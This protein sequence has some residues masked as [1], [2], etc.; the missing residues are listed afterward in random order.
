MDFGLKDIVRKVIVI[1]DNPDIFQT[2]CDILISEKDSREVDKMEAELFGH[3]QHAAGSTSMYKCE[4][5]YAPQGKDGVTIIK[6]ASEE[7][8]PFSLAFVDMRMPPGWNGLETIKHIWEIDPDIQAVICTAYS[9]YSW[10]ELVGHLGLTDNLLI[11]KKPFD[12]AEVSQ[13]TSA[14]TSKWILAKQAAMKMH[15]LEEMVKQHSREIL[16]AKEQAEK[17][18]QSKSDFLA[19]MS[20]EIRTPMTGVVGMSE[21]LLNTDL[22]EE[23][24]NYVEAIN[25]SSEMLMT[26]INDILDISKIEAGELELESARFDLEKAIEDIVR[27][28]APGANKKGV[29]LDLSF[30][31]W[32]PRQVIGD[33][34]RVRQIIF[35]L[36]GNAVKFTNEGNINIQVKAEE[37]DDNIDCTGQYLIEIKDSGIGMEPE[38]VGME[39]AKLIKKEG[40]PALPIIALTASAF[41]R[42]R[43]MCLESGMSDFISKPL[44]QAE[45]LRII[46][47]W[48]SKRK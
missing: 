25:A 14:M 17:A 43:E 31:P 32:I 5:Y 11:L 12:P 27:I 41:K 36:T 33:F 29:N 21:M 19:T 34:V 20:H 3:T 37:I 44:K 35:N 48:I 1:D 15:D 7:G 4:L 24:R 23:Q 38:I 10:E 28:L 26:I 39:A 18:N 16:I 13:I 47:K 22:D 40:F 6:Q 46:S 9:D 8:K 30:P 2:F 42:D 45:L